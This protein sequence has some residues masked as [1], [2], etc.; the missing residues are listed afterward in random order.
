MP[1]FHAIDIQVP[2]KYAR[3]LVITLLLAAKAN[4]VC[5]R[6]VF[7]CHLRQAMK[8]LIIDGLLVRSFARD[9][10]QSYSETYRNGETEFHL[11]AVIHF[12][13]GAEN[14]TEQFRETHDICK[15]QDETVSF[16]RDNQPLMSD[17]YVRCL[18]LRS[19][20]LSVSP[21]SYIG[22]IPFR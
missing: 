13:A 1:C 5:V 17:T 18:P 8:S 6:S 7:V 14:I 2:G 9:E 3:S 12:L 16:P 19:P 11:F 20:L 21:P 22:T 10:D 4:R 15:I